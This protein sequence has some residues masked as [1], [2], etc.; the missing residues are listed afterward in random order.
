MTPLERFERLA[1]QARA[2]PAPAV[3]V[4]DRV[5]ADLRVRPYARESV[6]PL[7]AAAGVSLL[8]A[9]LVVALTVEGWAALVD[10]L[11][12]LFQSITWVVL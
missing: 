9:S 4:V 11:A 6:L 2:E 7:W 12:G 8:A 1:V 10:P 5:L 3:D